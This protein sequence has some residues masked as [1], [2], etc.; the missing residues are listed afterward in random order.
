MYTTGES[1]T[2]SITLSGPVL[3]A[4][5]FSSLA[6]QCLRNSGTLVVRLGNRTKIGRLANPVRGTIGPRKVSRR[7][8]LVLFRDL[9]S[10]ISSRYNQS[11]FSDVHTDTFITV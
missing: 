8:R 9:S 1:P 3:L 7:F 2:K 4:L 5:S 6:A 10:I 11:P